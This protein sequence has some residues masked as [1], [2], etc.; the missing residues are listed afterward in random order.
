MNLLS[1]QLRCVTLISLF[2]FTFFF[3][4]QSC[5]AKANFLLLQPK[6]FGSHAPQQTSVTTWG[7]SASWEMSLLD[8]VFH[9]I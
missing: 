2:P 4:Q 5:R 8:V 9:F 6:D 1:P 3:L 7:S